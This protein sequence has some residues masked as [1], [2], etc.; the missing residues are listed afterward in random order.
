MILKFIGIGANP[1]C[2][3]STF[4]KAL[5][6]KISP[7]WMTNKQ[8]LVVF[9][10]SKNI[11]V[12]GSYARGEK[13]PGTD[14]LSMAAQPKVVEWLKKKNTYDTILF[15]GDRLFN[16]SF[17]TEVKNIPGIELTVVLLTCNK[18]KLDQRHKDRQD[19]QDETWLRGRESKVRNTVALFPNTIVLEHEDETDTK[20]AV[21]EIM[22]IINKS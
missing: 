14:R 12:L 2:G 4:M 3:K 11:A 7:F 20:I 10:S 1:A 15:E 17:L 22:K 13:F 5:M 9:E 16:G 8:G 19:T 18:E 6:K 21:S